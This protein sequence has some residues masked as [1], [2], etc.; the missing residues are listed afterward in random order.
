[1]ATV[2]AKLSSYATATR[3]ASVR[4]ASPSDFEREGRT[5]GSGKGP[6]AIPFPR[7]IF[8]GQRTRANDSSSKG[9]FLTGSV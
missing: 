8:M 6:T 1:M 2:E 9:G 5:D 3:D 7:R 4:L